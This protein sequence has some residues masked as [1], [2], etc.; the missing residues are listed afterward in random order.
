MRD[1]LAIA[2]RYKFNDLERE[3]AAWQQRCLGAESQL[4]TAQMHAGKLET[5]LAELGQQPST[6]LPPAPP[7][8]PTTREPDPALVA[9]MSAPRPRWSLKR[10]IQKIRNAL[11]GRPQG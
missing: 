8:P 3:L 7:P 1:S 4:R 2:A 11:K 9:Q 10:R 6:P 5:R